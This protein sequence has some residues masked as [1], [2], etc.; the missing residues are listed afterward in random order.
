MFQKLNRQNRPRLNLD[1]SKQFRFLKL[2]LFIHC[3]DSKF[4][5]DINQNTF[6]FKT[7]YIHFFCKD[8]C[9]NLYLNSTSAIFIQTNTLWQL[10]EVSWSLQFNIYGTSINSFYV[11]L[12]CLSLYRIRKRLNI[13]LNDLFYHVHFILPKYCIP[14]ETQNFDHL[15]YYQT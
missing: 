3:L 4:H 13:H 9:F 12:T 8:W 6:R 7:N 5:P 10:L 11:K 1:K 2:I 15:I 14:F